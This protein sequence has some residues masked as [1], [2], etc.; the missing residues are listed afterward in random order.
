MSPDPT[1]DIPTASGAPTGDAIG[2]QIADQNM[3]DA[4]LAHA[5]Q[6]ANPTDPAVGALQRPG[7]GTGSA[8][9]MPLRD[10][11]DLQQG[12]AG[13]PERNIQLLRDVTMRVKVELGRGK[14]H[15]R[16][17]L[18][19]TEGSVIELEKNA[20]DPLEIY[21]NDR[22]VAKGEVLVLNEN[23]CVRLT[24]IFSAEECM[25]LRGNG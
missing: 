9:S 14:M 17:V 16:D 23:F 19:L 4:L 15:L 12:G 6:G 8:G 10:F 13:D 2:D 20:G 24:Q 5:S 25:R 18:R 7:A 11:G 22:L 3:V 21:V 1:L